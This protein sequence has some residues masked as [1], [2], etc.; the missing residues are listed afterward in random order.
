MKKT[1]SMLIICDYRIPLIMAERLKQYGNL[2]LFKNENLLNSPLHGHTDLH[3]CET[4]YGLIIAPNIPKEYLYIFNQNKIKYTFGKNDVSTEHPKIA[5][6]NSVVTNK[7]IICNTKTTDEQILLK[8]KNKTIIDVKQSYCRCSTFAINDK[9]FIT[10]DLP[11][12]KKI[13]EKGFDSFYVETKNIILP[14]YPYGFIG[15]CLGVNRKIHEIV[16][17][18]SLSKTH[19][20]NELEKYINLKGYKLIQLS[21]ETLYDV[22]GIFFID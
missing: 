9:S 3:I 7:V 5:L 16:I 6:Y 14:D 10:S 17:T 15:G 8:N 22:G 1:T 21:N 12:H 4:P 18:G 11:T 19:I 20:N 13:L 2:V